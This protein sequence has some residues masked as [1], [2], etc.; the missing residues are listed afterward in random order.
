MFRRPF[1][2][3]IW[4]LVLLA[5]LAAPLLAGRGSAHPH[6]PSGELRH[7]SAEQLDEI[8]QVSDGPD[9]PAL[10]EEEPGAQEGDDEAEALGNPEIIPASRLYLLASTATFDVRDTA[11]GCS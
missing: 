3:R 7:P 9:D 11:S 10:Q 6:P 2:P 1:A 5:L 8:D 4:L